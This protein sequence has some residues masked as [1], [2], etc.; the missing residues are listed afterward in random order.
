M[1]LSNDPMPPT[2]LSPAVFL[3]RAA[4]HTLLEQMDAPASLETLRACLYTLRQ[5]NRVT[6]SY[7][8]T[9]A[10]LARA[11][12]HAAQQGISFTPDRPLRIL[13][14]GS[15]GGDTLIRIARWAAIRRLPVALTGVDLNPQS[16][17]LARE[18]EL[19]LTSR[20]PRLRGTP[21]TWLAADALTLTL[22][23]PPDLILSSLFMHHLEDAEI[24]RVLR[25]QHATAALGWFVNDLARSRRAARL[26]LAV[27]TVLRHQPF[28]SLLSGLI[29]YDPLCL[30]DGPVSLRRA[31]RPADWQR[32][33]AQAGISTATLIPIRPAR[34]CLEHLR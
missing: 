26:Y 8:P 10:F 7:R 31:F 15:G 23:N 30:H 19:R 17:V 4:P 11:R 6:G 22:P 18:A 12:Q 24:V 3:T 27:G 32:L 20:N 1:P 28:R 16:A 34:L 14:V 29:R 25:W 33:L 2:D 5:I 9:L 13:D 21:I